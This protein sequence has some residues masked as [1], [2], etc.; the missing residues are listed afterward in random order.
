MKRSGV[1][2]FAPL[3]GVLYVGL[4]VVSFVLSGDPPDT[5]ESAASFADHWQDK[6]TEMIVSAILQTYA[7][8]LL[9]WFAASLRSAIARVEEGAARLATIAFSGAVILAAGILVDGSIK[10]A[11]AEGADDAPAATTQTLSILYE[12]FFLIFAGGNALFLLGAGLALVRLRP[13]P[14]WL[15][16]VA[17]VLGVLNLTPAGFVAL[18]VSMVWILIVSVLLFRAEGA[19]A[20]PAGPE[21]P[22]AAPAGGV[23]GSPG[24]AGPPGDGPGTI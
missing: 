6:E 8:V 14:A 16:W 19:G 3:A 17:L 23:P 24:P 4:V 15:G 11:V 7:A 13:L 12:N 10:F 20:G 9:V 1:E 18:I 22:V 2:R 5:D 21:A